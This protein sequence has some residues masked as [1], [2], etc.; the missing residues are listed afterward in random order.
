MYIGQVVLSLAKRLM[1]LCEFKHMAWVCCSA[2]LK[3]TNIVGIH[4]DVLKRRSALVDEM[5]ALS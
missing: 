1:L 5:V 4:L 2:C 3:H